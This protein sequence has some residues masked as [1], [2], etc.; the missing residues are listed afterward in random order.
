MG[1]TTILVLLSVKP[2]YNQK[3]HLVINMAGVYNWNEPR[4][5]IKFLRDNGQNIQVQ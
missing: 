3:I 1:S 4:P 5:H 2:E